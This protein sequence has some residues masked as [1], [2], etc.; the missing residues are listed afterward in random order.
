MR[1]WAVVPSHD[2]QR[3][4][5]QSGTN[6]TF[7]H[8]P[9]QPRQLTP[10]RPVSRTCAAYAVTRS[11][12]GG[13]A[14]CRRRRAGACYG[15]KRSCRK[16]LA[17]RRP[18]PAPRMSSMAIRSR[19]EFINGPRAPA[20]APLLPLLLVRGVARAAFRQSAGAFNP[21]GSAIAVLIGRRGPLACPFSFPCRANSSAQPRA[22]ATFSGSTTGPPCARRVGS[23][24]RSRRKA[25]RGAAALGRSFPRYALSGNSLFPKDTVLRQVCGELV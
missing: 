14:E 17:H 21:R 15:R 4:R 12:G 22:D 9:F 16:P 2:P 3:P 25:D 20:S 24:G 6:S 23:D 18:S 13:V 19:S 11:I 1:R 10:T 7:V 8:S 5:C